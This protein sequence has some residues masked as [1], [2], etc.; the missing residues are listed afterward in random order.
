M[1]KMDIFFFKP[2]GKSS[3][4]SY[5]RKLAKAKEVILVHNT[6]TKEEDVVFVKRETEGASWCVCINANQYIENAIPPVDMLRKNRAH[7]VIGTDSLASNHT[8]SIL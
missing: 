6:F 7:I 8:L 2:S 1:M 3:L 4:Q 5:F